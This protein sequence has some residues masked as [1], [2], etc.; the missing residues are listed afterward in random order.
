VNILNASQRRA[1][2]RTR[3][4]RASSVLP[5]PQDPGPPSTSA[6]RCAQVRHKNARQFLFDAANCPAIDTSPA[7]THGEMV[8]NV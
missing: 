8:R 7:S 2:L 5:T 1:Q 6:E 3:L 4:S